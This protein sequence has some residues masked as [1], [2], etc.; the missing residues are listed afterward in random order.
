VGAAIRAACQ[1][2]GRPFATQVASALHDNWY[3]TAG[4]LAAL[5]DETARS[6]GIPLRLKAVVVELLAAGSSSGG[7]GGSSSGSSAVQQPEVQQGQLQ[8]QRGGLA[9]GLLGS[10]AQQVEHGAQVEHRPMTGS[11]SSSTS[12]EQL[13]AN[14]QASRAGSSGGSSASGDSDGAAI[15][16]AAMAAAAEEAA[17]SQG[18]RLTAGAGVE[19]AADQFHLPIE[20]RMCPPLGRFEHPGGSSAKVSKRQ[21]P[22]RYA[23]S[24]SASTR[25]CRLR[26]QQGWAK[27]RK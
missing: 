18:G 9:D 25:L 6:L 17:S 14:E 19:V 10:A 21:R 7:S 15:F 5:P 13:E 27:G 20:Q 1:Q 4:E 23:L 2:L 16:A 24:V 22:E 3:T 11:G 26:R 12:S 8:E